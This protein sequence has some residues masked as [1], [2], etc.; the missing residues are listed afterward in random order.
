[1]DWLYLINT[2]WPI[3]AFLVT[4]IGGAFTYWLMSKV[5][6]KA[7]HDTLAEKVT[8]HE[9]ILSNHSERL[10]QVEAHIESAPTRQELQD[11]ISELSARMSAMEEGQNGIV[12]Q[13]TT[14]N[15][16]LHTLI[17]KAMPGAGPR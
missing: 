10:K 15:N 14:I 7:A 8:A 5:P 3:V 11:D 6:S 16:Y 12:R 17:E 13:L 1:M 9:L 2:F 4:V